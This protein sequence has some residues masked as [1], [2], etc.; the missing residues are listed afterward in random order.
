MEMEASRARSGSTMW[1]DSLPS[2]IAV[3][4]GGLPAPPS[5]LRLR[6]AVHAR[7]RR[8]VAAERHAVALVLRLRA[9]QAGARARV[10]RG[11][12]HHGRHRTKRG[13]W[14][15]V[16]RALPLDA[17]AD[18]D[19]SGAGGGVRPSW[20]ATHAFRRSRSSET[21]AA[22]SMIAWLLIRRSSWSGEHAS[23]SK[24]ARIDRKS[25]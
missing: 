11:V 9:R 17:G 25:V 23:V 14:I 12:V 19:G 8:R 24:T 3:E 21:P 6:T 5:S 22:P 4:G 20:T 7:R 10:P 1:R 16:R 18:A 13:R 2:E 15:G